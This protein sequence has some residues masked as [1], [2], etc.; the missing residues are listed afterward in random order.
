MALADLADEITVFERKTNIDEIPD[1]DVRDVYMSLYHAHLPKLEGANL[2]WYDQKRNTVAFEDW[3]G[4]ESNVP[5]A[6]SGLTPSAATRT[7]DGI[8]VELSPDTVEAMHRT[9]RRDDRFD[10]WMS[11]DELVRAVFTDRDGGSDGADP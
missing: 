10:Q 4:I 11:Y 3:G 5:G 8:T 7:S 6:M 9:I 2:L 1:E